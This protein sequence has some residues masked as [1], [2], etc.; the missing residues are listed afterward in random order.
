MTRT[1]PRVV[2]G[3]WEVEDFPGTEENGDQGLV[4]KMRPVG[5]G[6]TGWRPYDRAVMRA[7]EAVRRGRND[8]DQDVWWTGRDSLTIAIDDMDDNRRRFCA[9]LLIDTAAASHF[10]R[11]NSEII[12]NYW[13][14][15]DRACEKGWQIEPEPSTARVRDL[16]RR[17]QQRGA[18][19]EW[20]RGS[21]L[22]QRMI[23]DLTWTH[24][25]VTG[26]SLDHDPE[27]A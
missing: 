14:Y 16:I 19:L 9:R 15:Y 8:L 22:F 26:T 3:G 21:L 27:K 18:H 4:T 10:R 12:G 11:R 5:S 17:E 2:I 6:S 24:P 20:V 1:A 25:G 7:A 23:R 13:A